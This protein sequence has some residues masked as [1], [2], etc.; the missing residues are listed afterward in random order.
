MWGAKP[1]AED[2]GVA[3]DALL[4]AGRED[5]EELALRLLGA[6]H[7]GHASARLHGTR[8]LIRTLYG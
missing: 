7:V 8:N 1:A 2:A 5:V 6:K 4:V 3:A